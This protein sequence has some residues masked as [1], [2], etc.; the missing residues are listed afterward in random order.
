MKLLIRDDFFESVDE[1]R[2]IAL[3]IDY[4]TH[5]EMDRETKSA[6]WKGSR[7]RKLMYYDKVFLYMCEQK[8]MKAVKEYFDDKKLYMNSYFHLTFNDTKTCI[9]NF[10]FE[11]YHK[12]SVLYAGVVYLTPDAP[13]EAGTSILNGNENKIFNAENVYNRLVCY[14]G[15]YVHAVSDTF[16]DTKETA[17]MTLSFFIDKRP[18]PDD[19]NPQ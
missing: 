18:L 13:R 2:K 4:V 19:G 11:K 7:S 5:Q 6:G 12:D 1:L 14:P 9:P 16:G 10:G 17:R 15:N 3:S 8:I